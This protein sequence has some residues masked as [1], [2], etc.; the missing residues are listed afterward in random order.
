MKKDCFVGLDNITL[1]LSEKLA[2]DVRYLPDKE[3]SVMQVQPKGSGTEVAICLPRTIRQGMN[4]IPLRKADAEM[5]DTV[6]TKVTRVFRKEYPQKDILFGCTV[7]SVEVGFTAIFN[8]TEQC[9]TI[10]S[11]LFLFSHALLPTEVNNPQNTWIVGKQKEEL[12]YIKD[13]VLKSFSLPID[14]CKRFSRKCY[15][16]GIGSAFDTERTIDKGI[17]RY[18]HVYG[19]VGLDFVLK[20]RGKPIILADILQKNVIYALVDCFK[21]DC[22]KKLLPPLCGLVNEVT[23]LFYNEMC[24]GIKPL[25]VILRNK[26]LLYDYAIFD[27]ALRRFYRRSGRTEIAYRKQSTRLKKRLYNEGIVFPVGTVMEVLSSI[28]GELRKGQ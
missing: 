17:L 7:K 20:Q 13:V 14:S 11:L 4:V 8:E 3:N 25:D 1:T 5:L 10:D 24:Y 15:S 9:A 21:L 22:Q 2:N 18:E 26:N 6:T 16:K 28:S 27:K 12:D 23:D 19:S